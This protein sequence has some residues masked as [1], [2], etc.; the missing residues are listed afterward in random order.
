MARLDR[1]APSHTPSTRPSTRIIVNAGEANAAI[2]PTPSFGTRPELIID[3]RRIG[4]V[5]RICIE[6]QPFLRASRCR[7]A[8][9]T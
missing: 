1:E 8:R 2:V 6:R 7:P 9:D 3:R 5:D 4:A